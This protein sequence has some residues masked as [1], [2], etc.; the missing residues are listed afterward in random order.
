M[1]EIKVQIEKANF[2]FLQ[3]DGVTI[4]FC[5]SWFVIILQYVISR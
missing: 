3:A 5:Q 4:I 1:D 2:V